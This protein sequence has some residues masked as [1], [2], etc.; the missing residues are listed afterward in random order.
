[1]LAE[2]RRIVLEEPQQGNST[3]TQQHHTDSAKEND[4]FSF[5]EETTSLAENQV[6]DY[7]R[8]SAQNVD[9]VWIFSDQENFAML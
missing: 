9:S 3:S 1:M 6:A 8:S 4:L 7:I 5:E 2:C